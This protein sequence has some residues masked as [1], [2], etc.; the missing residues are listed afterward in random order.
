MRKQYLKAIDP[1]RFFA[2]QV[3]L[4][5]TIWGD[6]RTEAEN[7]EVGRGKNHLTSILFIKIMLLSESQVQA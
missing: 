1:Q 2:F 3:F 7:P 4:R 5:S 6:D